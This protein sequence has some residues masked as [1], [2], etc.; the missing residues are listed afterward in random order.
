VTQ[1]I[2]DRV[3]A[4]ADSI[5]ISEG[6]DLVEVEFRREA[7]GWVLRLTL[8]KSGGV[9]LDD[10]TR[11]SRE[12]GRSLDVEDFIENP[13]HLEVSSPGLDRSLKNERD[14]IRFSERRIKVKT[15][16][17]IG[18]QKSFK[19]KLLKCVEGRIEME[20]DEGIVEIP[21]PNIAR[22][23]LEVEF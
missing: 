2:I 1:E 7:G 8:D 5:L 20:T 23:N 6:M 12:I 22:A 3:R 17:P 15:M 10:C 16:E 13:Y 21:L 9:T 4:I 18:K 11:M 19:G 14:F